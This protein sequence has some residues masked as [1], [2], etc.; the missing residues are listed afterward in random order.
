MTSSEFPLRGI[1]GI[2]ANDIEEVQQAKQRNLYCVE[3]RPD[4]LLDRGHSESDVMEIISAVKDADLSCLFTLRRHDHGGKFNGSDRE[5]MQICLKAVSTGADIVDVEWDS[6]CAHELISQGI[7]TILSNHNFGGMLSDSEL[8]DVTA[9]IATL[10]PAAI[11][12]VPTAEK[13]S[14]AIRMLQ[15][16]ADAGEGPIRIGFAMGEAGES[17]RILTCS[18]GGPITYATFDAPVA[19]GQIP[20]DLL[21]KQYQIDNVDSSTEIIGIAG[22]HDE[23]D[24]W[25]EILNQRFASE[26]RN[27]IAVPIKLDDYATVESNAR[28]LRMKKLIVSDQ[29]L[30]MLPQSIRA[31]HSSALMINLNDGSA[32]PFSD[33]SESVTI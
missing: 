1:I 2:V 5:Q 12:I 28:F 27:L 25:L 13:L 22:E 10:N 24:K 16:V 30:Q 23:L 9:K 20:I 8:E 21:Q 29:L 32:V 31:S 33:I 6:E 19:P 17:S 3:M 14:D 15:W 4:L 18:F 26:G 7:P 11:K